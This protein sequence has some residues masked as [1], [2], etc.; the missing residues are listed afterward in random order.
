MSVTGVGSWGKLWEMCVGVNLTYTLFLSTPPA[1]CLSRN[2]AK[3]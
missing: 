1:Y 3:V 2:Y